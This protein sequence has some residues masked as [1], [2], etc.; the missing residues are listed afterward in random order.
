MMARS[1]LHTPLCD[2]LRIEHPIILAGMG[3]VTPTG[4]AV[5]GVATAELVA[6]VSEA[7]GLGVI[8]GA[9]MPPPILREQIRKVRSLTSR[10]FGVNLLLLPDLGPTFSGA[11]V[12]TA[13]KHPESVLPPEYMR[14]VEGILKEFDLP[15]PDLDA[16]VPPLG[17]DNVRAQIDVV[18]EERV[19]AFA[20]GL[21]SPGP[22]VRDFHAVGTKVF[23]SAG[24]VEHARNHAEAG[25]DLIVAQGH[26]AGGHTGRVGTMVLVP[27][28][29]DAV[30]PIPVVAA[31]GI[32]DGR[33]IVAALALGACGA[34]MGTAFMVA[35]EANWPEALKQRIIAAGDSETLVTRLYSGK[36]MR[37][38][39]NKIIDRW[40]RSGLTALPM[41]LQILVSRHLELAIAKSGQA[42]LMMNPAGAIAG[43][44]CEIRP[45]REIMEDLVQSAAQVRS[46]LVVG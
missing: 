39:K 6:A 34:W 32:G 13:L 10:P 28:V 16:P 23:A 17:G 9:G 46:A 5:N 24:T 37:N 1:P 18:L 44:L 27:Q 36:P 41:P 7:G 2:L 45:A 33:G 42:D 14:W 20:A 40:E 12:A 15:A 4:A 25:V 38:L 30:A 3:M 26:E 21:G 31:G 11:Q 29:V 22:Y 19:A 43:M 35:K 8:G